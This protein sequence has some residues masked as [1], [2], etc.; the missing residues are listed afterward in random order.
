M[1]PTKAKKLE[2]IP[3]ASLT[4]RLSEL[5]NKAVS[6][7]ASTFDPQQ[8]DDRELESGALEK[9]RCDLL[10]LNQPCVFL[11]ILVLQLRK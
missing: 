6:K 4:S 9:L 2:V 1:E 5:L 11:H 10:S 3:V 8:P 7:T